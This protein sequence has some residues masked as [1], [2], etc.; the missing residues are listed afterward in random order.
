MSTAERTPASAS[1]ND[2]DDVRTLLERAGLRH[3]GFAAAGPAPHRSHFR[4][5][6][7]RG[8]AATMDYLARRVERREDPRAIVPGAQT[9]IVA[10]IPYRGSAPFSVA[11]AADDR[12][13]IAAYAQGTDYHRVL[14]KR[15][16]TVSRRLQEQ[17]HETF[18]YY[19][20][21]GPVL[22][23]DWAQLAGVGWIGKNTCTLRAANG[24]FLFLA[25]IITTLKL[26]PD[27]PATNHCG[28]CQRCLDAC[29]TDAFRGPYELDAGRCI[30]YLNIEH[31]GEVDPK[32][33]P[34]LGNLVFG[35]DICQEVCPFNRPERLEADAEL[36]P[37]PE[38]LT[39]RL[40]ELARLD[41]D[42]FRA[43]FAQSAVRRAKFEG[44]MRNVLIAMGNS[45]HPGCQSELEELGKREDI[46][47]N[48]VLHRTW[49]RAL[50][51]SKKY[52]P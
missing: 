29:P 35:C 7:D 34:H 51:R 30:S 37:R 15:L 31:R 10:A 5:W 38:N 2:R 18:R 39:P 52:R 27:A 26:E 46:R 8:F 49:Q 45:H 14:E 32:L 23:R 9:V 36:K 33:E 11:K 47:S 20:D 42:S 4:A 1:H 44:F 25:V 3:V 19:V 21:T 24:S 28:T 17:Y 12:A 50:E 48:P 6:L 40:T 22:E 13:E 43:R 16:K 41:Q